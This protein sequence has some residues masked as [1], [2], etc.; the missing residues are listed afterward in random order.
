MINIDEWTQCFLKRHDDEAIEEC[1]R[2]ANTN[3]R[4]HVRCTVTQEAVKAQEVWLADHKEH[5][6][7]HDRKQVVEEFGPDIWH[8]CNEAELSEYLPTH[9]KDT[10]DRERD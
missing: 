2:G 9:N 8:R 3:E 1:D 10:E 5:V 6:C 4:I 7:C